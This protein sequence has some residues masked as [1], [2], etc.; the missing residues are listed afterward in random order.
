MTQFT[1]FNTVIGNGKSY[2]VPI[3]Q[4]DFSWEKAEWEDLWNDIEEIPNDKTHYLGYLVF[5]QIDE[6]GQ[7]YLITSL[8]G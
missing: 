8:A 7:S 2:Q 4:R 1:N 5:Q 6:T 3:Y